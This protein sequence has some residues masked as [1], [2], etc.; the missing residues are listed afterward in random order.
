M[1]E[2]ERELEEAISI[3]E[4]EA[5]PLS[6]YAF[7]MWVPRTPHDRTEREFVSREV[8]RLESELTALRTALTAADELAQWVSINFNSR[9]RG[10]SVQEYDVLLIR[11]AAYRKARE[12][13]S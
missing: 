7:R 12:A 11:L 6:A 9:N 13:S 3:D 8:A 5:E 2:A 10:L 4:A 1:N